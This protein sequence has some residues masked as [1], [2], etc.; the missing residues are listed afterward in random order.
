MPDVRPAHEARI[1]AEHYREMQRLDDAA[2]RPEDFRRWLAEG[3]RAAW[4]LEESIRKG[5]A[6]GAKAAM[7]TV[8][9]NCNACHTS[10]RNKRRLK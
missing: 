7:D 1:L 9:A 2:S 4:S 6:D 5:D 10:Y 8:N 3:E